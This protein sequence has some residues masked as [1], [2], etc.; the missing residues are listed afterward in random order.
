MLS[1]ATVQNLLTKLK[2][3]G[4]PLKTYVND[5]IFYG[6]K[7]GLNEAFV[8][9]AKTR[10]KLIADD[11]RS[12]EV[13]K[14]FLAGRDIKRYQSPEATKFLILFE[15]G[16]TTKQRGN[17]EPEEWLSSTYPAV[18]G[19]LKPFETKAKARSDK[20]LFWWELRAC[21]YYGEFEKPHII[22]P[23]IIKS[24]S[25]E[26]DDLG[27]YSND[28]TTI[29]GTSDKYILAILNS[30][31]AGYF[32]GLISATKQGGYFEY[33]PVY[34]AQI[35]IPPATPEQKAPITALVNQI[36]AAKAADRT[37]DTGEL[38]AEVDQLV[39]ELYGLSAEE[40]GVIVPSAI[41]S[42]PLT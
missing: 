34:I 35:P 9:D 3:T 11:P 28:K 15:R 42:L 26:W 1:D 29:V 33:K 8:I 37:T 20:G 23:S 2:Q 14:P 12:A 25:C 22:I 4:Q 16:I 27:F 13:I 31:V 19:W 21:E 38:E 7:T 5:K 36:L 10:D 18:Y 39:Y 40:I 30:K 32:M 6:I 41:H 17:L 24:P